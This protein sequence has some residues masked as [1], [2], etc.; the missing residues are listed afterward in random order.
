M[1]EAL[2]STG[3][4]TACYCSPYGAFYSCLQSPLPSGT[5]RRKKFLEIWE[6]SPQLLEVRSIRGRDL[7]TCSSCAHLGTCTRCPGLAYMEGNMRGPS[8]ADCEKSFARTG[9][10]TANMRAGGRSS[11]GLGLEQI[12]LA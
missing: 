7:P 3:G 11:A 5:G 2:P 8:S 10:P 12:Q 9:I 6:N 1:I 4:H